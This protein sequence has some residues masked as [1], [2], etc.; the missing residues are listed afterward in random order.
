MKALQKI[1]VNGI[2]T[3]IEDFIKLFEHE[4][5]FD[6]DNFGACFDC[7]TF[8]K[9]IDS[10]SESFNTFELVE[11]YLQLADKPIEVTT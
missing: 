8:S 3:A 4:D 5:G 6:A 11:R 7:D 2:S 1:L 10:F 9:A